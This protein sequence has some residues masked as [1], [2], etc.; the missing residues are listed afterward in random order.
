MHLPFDP[1]LGAHLCRWTHRHSQKRIDCRSVSRTCVSFLSH[2]PEASGWC[3]TYRRW[4]LIQWRFNHVGYALKRWGL[5]TPWCATCWPSGH[6][7]ILQ[8]MGSVSKDPYRNRCAF[9]VASKNPAGDVLLGADPAVVYVR[10]LL[11][12][13]CSIWHIWHHGII[14]YDIPWIWSTFPAFLLQAFQ[15]C[16]PAARLPALASW[17]GVMG[18]DLCLG[19]VGTLLWAL[20][21]L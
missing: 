13:A 10:R 2:F 5:C 4:C 12:V 14:S 7:I 8:L 16:C 11:K 21:F 9:L 6:G 1:I 15:L 17:K 3:S 20:V 18:S 19:H